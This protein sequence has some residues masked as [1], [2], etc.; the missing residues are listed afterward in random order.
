MRRILAIVLCVAFIPVAQ[1]VAL[2]ASDS[3]KSGPQVGEMIP[4]PFHFLNINGTFA[5]DPHCL[6]CEYGLRPVVAV[7]ARS[8]PEE[9]DP[10]ATLL[11]K[12]DDTV[13][14]RQAAELRGFAAFLNADYANEDSRK[15]LVG[16]LENIAKDLKKVILCVGD[17]KGPEKYNINKDADVTV[18]LYN[19]HQVVAN[20]AFAKEKLTDKDVNEIVAAIEKMAPKK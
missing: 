8:V 10:L 19:K 14:N 3:L 18:V 15:A 2:D 5:G 13:A 16:K 6:V 12:I 11:R 9:K 20:F 7:F 17:D 4:G 1:S